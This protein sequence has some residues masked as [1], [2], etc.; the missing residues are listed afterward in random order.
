M[1]LAVNW[2]YLGVVLAER[3]VIA[4]EFAVA[5]WMIVCKSEV[6]IDVADAL[7]SLR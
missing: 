2:R 4:L 5:G 3:L 1:H 6:Y 7:V